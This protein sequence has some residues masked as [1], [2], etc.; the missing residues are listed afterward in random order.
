[1]SSSCLGASQARPLP[2]PL[3]LL[4]PAALAFAAAMSAA[5]H[6][7]E[8]TGEH[9]AQ[10]RPRDLNTT[11]VVDYV[12]VLIGDVDARATCSSGGFR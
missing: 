7:A 1:M 8:H 10:G 4:L 9:T 2:A 6:A 11:A 3:L 5:L 12:I